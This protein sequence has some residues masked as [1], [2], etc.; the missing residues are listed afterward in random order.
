MKVLGGRLLPCPHSRSTGLS[1][2]PTVERRSP[3]SALGWSYTSTVMPTGGVH[4]ERRRNRSILP[5]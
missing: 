4:H 5:L 3:R 1:P 2:A